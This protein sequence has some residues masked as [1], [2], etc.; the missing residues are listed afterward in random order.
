MIIDL[1]RII[2]LASA[3]FMLVI[4]LAGCSSQ[5]KN[6]DKK[7]NKDSFVYQISDTDL[8]GEDELP[9]DSNISGD[10][11]V[12]T[13]S[14][15]IQLVEFS[16][17]DV[18]NGNSDTLTFTYSDFEYG[19][20]DNSKLLSD[21]E[22]YYLMTSSQYESVLYTVNKK[23]KKMSSLQ[24]EN[25]NVEK[26][27]T[28]SNGAVY[29]LY[30]KY[31]IRNQ[32]TMV[33]KYVN[34]Q[35]VNSTDAA[36]LFS[37]GGMTAFSDIY[38]DK[39]G[40][41]FVLYR[42]NND[43]CIGKIDN[44][45]KVAAK[46]KVDGINGNA[47][48][49]AVSGKGEILVVNYD[50]HRQIL[51][52]KL[53]N[54]ACETVDFYEENTSGTILNGIGDYDYIVSDIDGLIGIQADK[55]VREV[56]INEPSPKD[57][58]CV[59]NNAVIRLNIKDEYRHILVTADKKTN[60][61]I[62]ETPLDIDSNCQ[63]VDTAFKNDEHFYLCRGDD[64]QYL[65]ITNADG[66]IKK[67]ADL[68]KFTENMVQSIN[69]DKNNNIYIVSNDNF[70]DCY[71][72]FDYN[73][74]LLKEVVIEQEK[75]ALKFIS[76]GEDL[77][78]FNHD[79]LLY[80]VNFEKKELEEKKVDI[81][82][83]NVYSCDDM[84]M[85]MDDQLIVYTNH[86]D[87]LTEAINCNELDNV[88]SSD[89]EITFDETDNFYFYSN[90]EN[91]LYKVK[92]VKPFDIKDAKILNIAYDMDGAVLKKM[93]S[94]FKSENADVVVKLSDYSSDEKAEK[95]NMEIASGSI[96]DIIISNGRMELSKYE[97]MGVLVDFLEYFEK[98]DTINIDD[99]YHNI[100]KA[101]S[102]SGKITQIVPVYS[103]VTG[104]GKTSVLGSERGWDISEFLKKA[105]ENPEKEILYSGLFRNNVE[106]IDIW[107]NTLCEYI[108][109]EN[110]KFE[111]DD[112]FTYILAALKP[113]IYHD[114]DENLEYDKNELSY[115]FDM[116]FRK[117]AV[118]FDVVD[119][120]SID[121]FRYL[122]DAVVS[123]DMVLKGFP[124]DKGTCSYVNPHISIAMLTSCKEK[125]T[126]WKFIRKY[127]ENEYQ[128]SIISNFP[129]KKSS[130]EMI[131]EKCEEGEQYVGDI[132]CEIHAPS[133]QDKKMITKWIE[134]L[135][136]SVCRENRISSIIYGE[137]ERYLNNEQN[138]DK[139][140]K[141]VKRKIEL[142]LSE[143]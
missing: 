125:D 123:E 81:N 53:D 106:Y 69:I 22:N 21:D 96:P 88:N 64:K 110:K 87:A 139:T 124:S 57:Y 43:I 98:D 135:N 111:I 77:Y 115:D 133:L 27:C 49:L 89:I 105:E 19:L 35:K 114:F 140:L 16:S 136:T 29:V 32:Y 132:L 130:F 117:D 48:Q 61:I 79:F 86:N 97:N 15:N 38:A 54:D 46:S 84:L 116:R 74:N 62:S 40:N 66:K 91:K 37:D 128:D 28:D 30:T 2:S 36:A 143:T 75:L 56:L 45:G 92:K 1:K 121:T 113:Y 12:V 60:Q 42:S 50:N 127:L 72:K 31:D 109:F 14:T 99:Y 129:V 68:E 4:P 52:N 67:N 23:D 73:L 55:G 134:S 101:C 5:N 90:G 9:I 83:S 142:Y 7:E 8:I 120:E 47:N 107:Y 34:G 44:E 85:I 65:I 76:A 108:D 80:R 51:I 78:V 122:K 93:V 63:I 11:L 41:I 141:E 104:F 25:L 17:F 58:Q 118:L 24:F 82:I 95:L 6:T 13:K 131:F 138:E 94:E 33:E 71:Q 26:I 112:N 126:A 100:F 39:D 18:R 102:S 137:L 10:N 103:V 20:R 59:S 70:N 3:L 119:I